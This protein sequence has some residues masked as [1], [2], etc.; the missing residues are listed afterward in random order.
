MEKNRIKRPSL[1]KAKR[2]LRAMPT[3]MFGDVEIDLSTLPCLR[4]VQKEKITA[5][6]DTDLLAEIRSFARKNKVSYA[7]VMND[8]LRKAF[9]LS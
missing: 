4:K 9:G 8:I 5:N 2:M 6:L 1:K 3:D 7:N